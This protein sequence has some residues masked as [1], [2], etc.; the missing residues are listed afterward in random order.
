[1]GKLLPIMGLILFMYPMQEYS[2]SQITNNI[3][4]I[5]K[6]TFITNFYVTGEVNIQSRI[7]AQV[8]RP[9]GATLS[10]GLFS[11]TA[12]SPIYM[13][14]NTLF[15][16]IFGRRT[17]VGLKFMSSAVELDG[18]TKRSRVNANAGYSVDVSTAF[19]SSHYTAG[20]KDL[21]LSPETT[22]ET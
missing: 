20:E 9:V 14:L 21:N 3:K 19:T 8:K 11:G 2:V 17:G 10:A 5:L 12:D 7:D 13:R 16:T 18:K 6:S 1:M 22:I 15:G 4:E